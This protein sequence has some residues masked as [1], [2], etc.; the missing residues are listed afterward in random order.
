MSPLSRV[1]IVVALF[2]SMLSFVGCK[3]QQAGIV[4]G[5][6]EDVNKP[7]VGWGL[8]KLEPK[9]YPDMRV[10]WMDQTNLE[11][12]IDKSLQ[13][14]AAPSSVRFYP[15]SNPGDTIT[16][17]QIVATL[18][19]IKGLIHKNITPEQFQ[20]EVMFLWIRPLMS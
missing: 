12:A 19:D 5:L 2:T 11:R 1:L 17:D 4:P 13:F 10:A 9:D 20:Q 6:Q 8:R 7:V 3:S 18:Y 16:H 14:L 15:S